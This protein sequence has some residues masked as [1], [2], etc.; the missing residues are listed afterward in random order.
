MNVCKFVLSYGYRELLSPSPVGCR[1]NSKNIVD[2]IV[3]THFM[4]IYYNIKKVF[5][6]LLHLGH[7]D[8]DKNDIWGHLGLVP[9]RNSR[10]LMS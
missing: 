8:G 6:L 1:D 9:E 10:Q 4:Y 5:S 3:T 2:Q 7:S